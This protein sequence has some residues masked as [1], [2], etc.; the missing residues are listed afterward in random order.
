MNRL[1]PLLVT[2]L[3]TTPEVPTEMSC[4][5]LDTWML[6]NELGS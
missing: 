1:V 2:I 4:A 3:I 5:P 6:S